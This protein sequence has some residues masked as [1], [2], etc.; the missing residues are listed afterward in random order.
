MTLN[1]SVPFKMVR[2]LSY[3]SCGCTTKT[4]NWAF[5]EPRISHFTSLGLGGSLCS[6]C[7]SGIQAQT[8]S[9]WLAA[10]QVPLLT[11]TSGDAARL[12]ALGVYSP[13]Q[14]FPYWLTTAP[15]Q[16]PGEGTPDGLGSARTQV[17]RHP[18]RHPPS[19]QCLLGV[20]GP[21][22]LRLCTAPALLSALLFRTAPLTEMR[23]EGSGECAAQLWLLRPL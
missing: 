7:T 19:A 11:C 3:I 13:V 5:Q 8:K 15:P 10:G 9:W 22:L 20:V 16:Y 14:S 21:A 18:S 17:P 12:S 1:G 4:T 6:T 23:L 2:T